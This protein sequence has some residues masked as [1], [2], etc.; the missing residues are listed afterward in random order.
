MNT[1][2][3][4][5][6]VPFFFVAMMLVVQFLCALEP[7]SASSRMPLNAETRP[8]FS[9]YGL[10]FSKHS[11]PSLTPVPLTPTDPPP[12]PQTD[13]LH[14]MAVGDIMMHEPQIT[15]GQFG[16]TY[17]F[18]SF[19]EFIAP[20]LEVAD[21]AFGNLETTLAGKAL[22]YAGY[23]MFNAPDELADALQAAHFDVITTANNHS[24]DRKEKGVLRTLEQLDRVGLLH[25]GTFASAEARD[26]PLMLTKNN[27]TLGV[28]AYSYGTN[29]VKIPDGKPY[30]IN[31][32]DEPLMARDIAAARVAGADFVVVNLHFGPEYKRFP[33]EW[34]KKTVDFLFDAGADLIFGSH[35]HVV[36]PYELR[37]LTKPDGSKRTGAVIYSLGNFI[38]NQRDE[39]RD[40]G[41]IFSLRLSKTGGLSRIDE[42]AFIPTYVHRYETA[43]RRVYNVLHMADLLAKR[44]Y[45]PLSAGQ[46]EQLQVRYDEM[47]EHVRRPISEPAP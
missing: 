8:Y 4:N 7:D 13:R 21:L 33:S 23:P 31:L 20:T 17:D 24:L 18:T 45:A 26:Q 29:G 6:Y 27:I 47:M 35:P 32:I 11:P 2:R 39:P 38:S 41:G 43:G 16:D 10:D 1:N 37:E 19:F 22:R 3:F 25:T 5:D 40:I 34:Q 46:Y 28:L 14:I 12:P 36:Q 44:D 30:L 15:A 42:A 9:G